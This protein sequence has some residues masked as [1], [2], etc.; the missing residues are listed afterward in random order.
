M[1]SCNYCNKPALYVVRNE[2]SHYAVKVAQ[3]TPLY[4]EEDAY[5]VA[6]KLALSIRYGTSANISSEDRKES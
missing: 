3:K 2:D 6:D 4:C 1:R 5:N